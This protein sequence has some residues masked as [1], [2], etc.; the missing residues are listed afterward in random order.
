MKNVYWIITLVLLLS[1]L[2]M[3]LLAVD[4]NESVAPDVSGTSSSNSKKG[5][6][7]SLKE[8]FCVYLNDEKKTVTLQRKEY[9]IGVVAA[10]MSADAHE[11]A[12]KAQVLAAHTYAYRKH[13]QNASADSEYDITN[14]TTL[15]QGYLDINSRKEKWGEK[16]DEF[17]KRISKIVDEVSDELIVYNGEPILAAYHAI[18]SGNTETAENVWGTNYP[19]LQS[20]SSVGDLLA[21]DY[22]SEVRV[23]E[24]AFKEA[25]TALGVAPAGESSTYIGTS[26]K[27]VAGTVLS[28]TLCGKEITGSAVR[29]KFSLRSAAFDLKYQDGVFIFSVMGYGHGVGMSQFGADY[30]AKQGSTYK[31]ILAAYYHGT[32]IVDLEK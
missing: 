28:I 13:L 31:E 2:L 21:P 14:D 30:M 11:E 4:K 22:L 26:K 17:E 5:D 18:S 16:A 32:N 7:L 15:D 29:E 1:F 8:T 23:E 24:A 27:S 9:L 25:L 10:E 6:K 12:L 3:P 19:Y 20:E